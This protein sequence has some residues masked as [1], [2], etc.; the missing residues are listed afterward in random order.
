MRKIIGGRLQRPSTIHDDM[1]MESIRGASLEEKSIVTCAKRE[2]CVEV[3][4]EGGRVDYGC[5]PKQEIFSLHISFPT[6]IDQKERGRSSLV[7]PLSPFTQRKRK[8]KNIATERWAHGRWT[9][10]FSI[11]FTTSQQI[12]VYLQP[13]LCNSYPRADQ[14]KETKGK[15][16]EKAVWA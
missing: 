3:G 14:K 6:Q 10:K 5:F 2:E 12:T 11:Q 16:K 1:G 7:V 13:A 15:K 8:K 9:R 4:E